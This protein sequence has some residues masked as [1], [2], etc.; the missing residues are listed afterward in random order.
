MEWVYVAL[1]CPRNMIIENPL[2]NKTFPDNCRN[3]FD[4]QA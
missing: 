1:S 3:S 2:E 4:F